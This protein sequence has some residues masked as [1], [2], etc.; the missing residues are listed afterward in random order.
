[1]KNKR[2]FQTTI[3]ERIA[4][5][6]YGLGKGVSFTFISG[7]L[8]LFYTDKLLLPAFAVSAILL[9]SKAW[10]AVNDPL[11]GIIVDRMNPKRGKF[12][13]W[14]LLGALLV[15]VTTILVFIISPDIAIGWRIALVVLTYFVW[16]F[17]FTLSDVPFYSIL[18]A[19][20]GNVNERTSLLGYSS[21]LGIVTTLIVNVGIVPKLNEIGYRTAGI[22]LGVIS[23]V[24]ML[25]LPLVA[26]ERNRENIVAEEKYKFKDI[27]EYIIRNKPMLYYYGFICIFG[28][29]NIPLGSHVLAHCLGDLGLTGTYTLYAVPLLILVYLL[30]PV[31]AKKVDRL[32]IFKFFVF[33]LIAAGLG[34]YFGGYK[35]VLIYGIFWVL[36]SVAALAATMLLFS[37]GPDFVEYGNY[38]TGMRKEGITIAVQSFANKFVAATAAALGALVLGFIKYDATAADFSPALLD[39]L[40]GWASLLPVA[41]LIVGLPLLFMCRFKSSDIQVMANI[42]N[43]TVSRA[44]G[45]A[46]LSRSYK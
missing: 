24:T 7:Y 18:S 23:L 11:F 15:P 30:I 21:I 4:F 8:M 6:L 13:P 39:K 26:K 35:S 38:V 25:A 42:N 29:F 41:G 43:G 40:F 33:V 5:P 36:K 28:M 16:D 32:T 9:I 37:F 22:L 31:I 1:M 10:D 17:A 19:M 20:T 45:E 44:E 14:L 46:Q 3:G 27:W 12:K 34:Q 2:N